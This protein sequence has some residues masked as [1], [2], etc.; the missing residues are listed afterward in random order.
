MSQ[1]KTTTVTTL[2]AA[3]LRSASRAAR[4]DKDDARAAKHAARNDRIRNLL[5][6]LREYIIDILPPPDA[7][8]AL[9]AEGKSWTPVFRC[10]P[11]KNTI[12]NINGETC[13]VPLYPPEKT[14][15][16]GYKPGVETDHSQDGVPLISLLQ[17]FLDP[18]TKKANPA[19]LPDARTTIDLLNEWA[20]R[21]VD[22]PEEAMC[23]RT[24]FNPKTHEL[25]IYLIWD[26]NAWDDHL[27]ARSAERQKRF[28]ERAHA[29]P[30]PG[31]TRQ[32]TF[33]QFMANKQRQRPTGAK[34]RPAIR[35]AK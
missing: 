20:L 23:F 6:Q 8:N 31:P 15:F 16:A 7:V 22:S 25:I 4:E 29:G 26:I 9:A 12:E 18:N 33:D 10:H 19:T 3:A 13:K 32:V 34:P 14:H 11:P 28:E 35:S 21:L 24:S 30:A 2:S 27:A 17:G 5:I 1:T